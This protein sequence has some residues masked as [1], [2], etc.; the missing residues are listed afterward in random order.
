MDL[1]RVTVRVRTWGV[2]GFCFGAVGFRVQGL[3]FL[4]LLIVAGLFI[5]QGLKGARAVCPPETSSLSKFR[6]TPIAQGP[7]IICT[8]ITLQLVYA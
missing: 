5:Y 4:G 7:L 8:E 1:M 2:S 6:E 3:G